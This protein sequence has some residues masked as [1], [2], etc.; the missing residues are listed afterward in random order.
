MQ[1]LDVMR[2]ARSLLHTPHPPNDSVL[3]TRGESYC[4]LLS[5]C[6]A[7]DSWTKATWATGMA[8]TKA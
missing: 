2:K 5:E 7:T 8:Q 1:L 6:C 4:T 3:G